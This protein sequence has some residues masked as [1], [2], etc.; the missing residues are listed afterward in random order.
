MTIASRR[1]IATT[2]SLGAVGALRPIGARRAPLAVALLAAIAVV[3]AALVPTLVGRGRSFGRGRRGRRGRSIAGSCRRWRWRFG[4]MRTTLARRPLRRT[5]RAWP[6]RM[7]LAAAR[8]PDLDHFLGRGLDFR[9]NVRW[10]L[11]GRGHRG[12]DLRRLGHRERRSFR[13]IDHRLP[14][15]GRRGVDRRNR[16]Y[17]RFNGLDARLDRRRIGRRL[18]DRL[19]R[20]F[21]FSC[22]RFLRRSFDTFDNGGGFA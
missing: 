15:L 21:N 4:S 1:A 16:L 6:A 12:L 11:R 17:A 2:M 22:R 20:R 13:Q 14:E 19:R 9:G 18:D 8:P 7:V 5:L 10:R 3:T